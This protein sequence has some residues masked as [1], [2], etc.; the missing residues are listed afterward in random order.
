MNDHYTIRNTMKSDFDRLIE[1]CDLELGNGYLSLISLNEIF[2]NKNNLVQTVVDAET[3]IIGLNISLIISEDELISDLNEYQLQYLS[4]YF[5]AANKIG[6]LKMIC[7]IDKAKRKG[8]GTQFI[9]ESLDYFATKDIK[10]IY[11]FAWKTLEGINMDTIF[12]RKGIHP[13]IEIE[14][15]WSDD[16]LLKN[17]SCPEC[18]L[19]PCKCS[20]V[21]YNKKLE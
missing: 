19:P 17:Y 13:F 9:R 4:P 18:G 14:N 7:L 11:A 2:E 15:Y 20:V 6:I 12:N 10:T 3:E 1:I 8:I 16:S 5:C 21:V